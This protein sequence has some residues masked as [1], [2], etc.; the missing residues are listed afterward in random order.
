MGRIIQ[1][2]AEDS[3][4][5]HVDLRRINLAVEGLVVQEHAVQNPGSALE[6]DEQ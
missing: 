5:V 1:L 2:R 6:E 3:G 4:G